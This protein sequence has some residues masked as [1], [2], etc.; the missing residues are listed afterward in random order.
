MP[1]QWFS[2]FDA[3]SYRARLLPALLTVLPVLLTAMILYPSLYTGTGAAVASLAVWCGALWFLAN[4]V[5]TLGRAAEKTLH[6]EWGGL[7]T[8]SM[9]RHRDDQLDVHTKRRYHRFLATRVPGLRLPTEADELADP[10]AA[11]ATYR[12]GVK[13]LF[14]YTRKASNF[15]LI[16][17]ENTAY[18]FRRNLYGVKPVG[19]LL[20]LACAAL[21][22]VSLAAVR[23]TALHAMPAP[24]LLLCVLLL[25]I[26]ACWVLFVTKTSVLDASRAYARAL[27]AACETASPADGSP[28]TSRIIVP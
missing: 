8:T 9:L 27:L 16:R 24:M 15:S 13:W 17:I 26:A 25:V 23:P 5:R 2:A 6:A 28:Q 22:G 21:T 18:G 20:C 12:S 4:V 19:L 11:D 7:P 10:I 1:P 3:Y 14:E